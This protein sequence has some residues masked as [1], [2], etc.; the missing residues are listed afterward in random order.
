MQK[1]GES[2]SF[3]DENEVGFSKTS[4]GLKQ[5]ERE[6]EGMEALGEKDK[7]EDTSRGL[8][9]IG[10]RVELGVVSECIVCIVVQWLIIGGS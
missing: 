8:L 2:V 3:I 7:N 10:G 4:V 9:G 5:R 1:K 6:R